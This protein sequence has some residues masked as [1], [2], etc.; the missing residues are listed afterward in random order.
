[1]GEKYKCPYCGVTFYESPENTK[2]RRIS[3]FHDQEDFE[4]IRTYSCIKADIIATYHYCPACHEYSVQLASEDDL[5]VFNYPPY[6]GMALPDYIPKAI[7]TDYI[8]ACAVLDSSPKAAATL[9]RRCLQG[10]IR[11][12][13]DVKAKN[14][15][16]EINLIKDKIPADQYEVLNGV[17]RLG[18]IGAHMENDVNLIVDIDPG[19]AQKLVKLLELLFKDWYIARNDRKALYQDILSIDR[20][21]RHSVI[22]VERITFC[23]RLAVQAPILTN[24]IHGVCIR[25]IARQRDGF[26]DLNH[27]GGF[28]FL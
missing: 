21:N 14:L 18:N 17:R 12:F 24:F 28:C 16:E 15:A 11:D 9:A 25:T 4:G 27:S 2:E 7:R 3:F 13:W 22:R 26:N 1:M 10:M 5:F 23:Q 6:T 19:E 20:T 8:E